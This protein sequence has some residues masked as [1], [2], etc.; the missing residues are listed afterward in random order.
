[1]LNSSPLLIYIENTNGIDL[2]WSVYQ[3]FSLHVVFLCYSFIMSLC[4]IVFFSVWVFFHEHSR[5]TGQQRKGKAISINSLYHFQP[6]HRHSTL[7][8]YCRESTSGHSWHPGSNREPLVSECR[9]LTTKLRVLSC[10]GN[11]LR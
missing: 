7:A 4:Y 2:L 8:G 5:F 3:I 1:M 10:F 11:V 6:L 9:S